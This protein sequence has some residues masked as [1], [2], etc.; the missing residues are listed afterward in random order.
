MMAGMS[1]RRS[2][3]LRIVMLSLM[4]ATVIVSGAACGQTKTATASPTSHSLVVSTSPQALSPPALSPPAVSPPVGPQRRIVVIGDSY[5]GGSDAGGKGDA[6]WAAL[7]WKDLAADQLP[8]IPEVSGQGGSGYVQRGVAKTILGEEAARLVRPDDN[9]V[10]FFGG[11][12]DGMV[13][14]E[15]LSSA[16]HAA[17]QGVRATAPNAVLLVIGPVWRYPDPPPPVLR[18]RDA[19]RDAALEAGAVFVDPIAEGWFTST[20]PSFIGFDNVHPTDA[21]HAYLAQQIE[22]HIRAA[23]TQAGV[24]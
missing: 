16:A 10:V 1:V 15:A 12:N 17:F 3:V 24:G 5:T 14:P 2:N 19:I 11:M 21:G 23:L 7:V 22:P 6:N 9:V 13:T 18:L 20:P 4:A 8:V